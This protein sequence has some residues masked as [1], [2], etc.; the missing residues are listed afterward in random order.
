MS[1]VIHNRVIDRS[2]VMRRPLKMHFFHGILKIHDSDRVPDFA[3][4]IFHEFFIAF[5]GHA[6]ATS[7][8][9]PRRR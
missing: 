4:E 5:F 2:V 3:P 8:R 6:L 9:F 7:S 1:I